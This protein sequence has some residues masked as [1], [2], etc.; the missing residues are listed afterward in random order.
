F[1][2]L[3]GSASGGIATS[4]S[5]TFSGAGSITTGGSTGPA[6]PTV[7]AV[8]DAAS[9]TANIA[10]GSIFVVKGINMSASG[11]TQFQFPLPTA[12]TDGVKITFT[13]AAGGA[14]VNPYLVYLYNQGSVNQL[15][16]VLPSTVATGNYNVTVTGNTGTTSAPFVVTVV[17]RKIGLI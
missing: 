14:G 15:A 10:Q 16:A 13:P 6:T 12:S 2:I 7:T 9:Y 17:Q 5:L 8:L 4:I 1:P 11:F 3:S